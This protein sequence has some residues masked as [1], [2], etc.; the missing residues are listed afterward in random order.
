MTELHVVLPGDIDDPRTPSGGNVYDR[1][2]CRGL[3]AAGWS[4]REHAVQGAWPRPGTTERAGLTRVLASLP[5]DSVVLIDGLVGSAVPEV[6]VPQ[7]QRLRLVILVHM[8]LGDG[9]VDQRGQEREALSAAVAVVT[10]SAWARRRLLDLYPLPADRVYAAPP[11]VD[12][13]ELVAGSAAGSE[14]LCVAAVT[15]YKGHDLLVEAL[16]TIA[17]LSWRCVCVGSLDRDPGYADRLRRTTRAYGMAD[18]ISFVGPRTGADLEAAYAAADLLV[19]ASRSETYGM[20]VTEAL[21]RGMPVLTTAA[22]GLPEALGRAPDGSLPGILV[23]PDDPAALAGALRRWLGE[24]ELRRA[25][26]RSARAR[27]TTLSGW[28]VTSGL[29]AAALAGI[30]TNAGVRP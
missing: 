26:R 4:V 17:E 14:L 7:A 13:A 23:R 12:P 6:L 27:R 8:P 15:P 19:L 24:P 29:I 25:L 30:A 11:G 10:T 20:V 16:A 18:Q 22:K 9:T 3:G 2:I 5:D 21:A 1:Q 28:P